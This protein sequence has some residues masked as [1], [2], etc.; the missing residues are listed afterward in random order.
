MLMKHSRFIVFS[1]VSHPFRIRRAFILFCSDPRWLSTDNTALYVYCITYIYSCVFRF[2]C[3]Y[4]K[5]NLLWNFLS[6]TSLFRLAEK[7]QNIRESLVSD[8]SVAFLT[9]MFNQLGL[10][11]DVIQEIIKKFKQGI[12]SW[13]EEICPLR[14]KRALTLYYSTTFCTLFFAEL[15]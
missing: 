15:L 6:L 1:Y 8:H 11:L 10:K 5:V 12:P 13:S 2:V 14:A 9:S 7:E 3:F 4:E